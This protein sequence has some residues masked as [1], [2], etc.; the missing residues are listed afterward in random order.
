M[1]RTSGVT[2]LNLA[3]MIFFILRDQIGLSRFGYYYE[4]QDHSNLSKRSKKI[5]L[6]QV[7]FRM[8]IFNTLLAIFLLF[9]S[10]LILK[11]KVPGTDL[12]YQLLLLFASRILPLASIAY[13]LNAGFYDG[14]VY[15]LQKACG[16]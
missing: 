2:T 11:D 7:M 5:W 9:S 10:E 13:I 1:F 4:I 6:F 14:A 12:S 3:S 16:I 15:G 8:I